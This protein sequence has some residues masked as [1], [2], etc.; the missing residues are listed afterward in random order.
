MIHAMKSLQAS[1]SA[2]GSDIRDNSTW[3]NDSL[4][5]AG[6]KGDS[7]TSLA[8]TVIRAK[9]QLWQLPPE[10][11]DGNSA[12]FFYQKKKKKKVLFMTQAVLYEINTIVKLLRL[13]QKSL[14]TLCCVCVYCSA[15][16]QVVC[17]TCCH[18]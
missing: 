11:A 15:R 10:A 13:M 14:F 7:L 8:D 3:D 4:S 12:D 18:F 6:G 17:S 2:T 16:L 5:G 1:S 9:S